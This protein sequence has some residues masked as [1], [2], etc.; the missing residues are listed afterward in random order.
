M[1]GTRPLRS[2]LAVM[3]ALA[4]CA[5]GAPSAPAP[6]VVAAHAPVQ[7]T[8]VPAGEA[9]HVA[10]PHDHDGKPLCQRCHQR[11]EVAPAVDPVALCSQCHDA[12][13]MKH[14]VR[15]AQAGT[16]GLP[17]LTGERIAC[18]TCHD[19]HDVKRFAHGLRMEYGALCLRCHV[20][21]GPR[22]PAE[23]APPAAGAAV[24]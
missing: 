3:A 21:H 15:V 10:N 13:R 8:P 16:P 2:A 4:A 14:P 9:V 7:F 12:A 1:A 19:P 22:A 17:L 5:H 23:S 11:G 24:H 20:R 18:H 6:A